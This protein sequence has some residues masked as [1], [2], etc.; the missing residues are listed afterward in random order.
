[1]STPKE[2]SNIINAITEIDLIQRLD[3][4]KLEY[5]DKTK[6][7]LV[8]IDI[9]QKQEFVKNYKDL[10]LLT[11]DDNSIPKLILKGYN[12]LDEISATN[13]L[14]TRVELNLSKL[15]KLNLSNNFITEMFDLNLTP[16]MKELILRENSIKTIRWEDFRPVKNSLE[17]FD[18]SLNKIDFVDCNKFLD[19]AKNFGKFMKKLDSFNIMGN[20]FS[21]KSIYKDYSTIFIFYIEANLELFLFNN[22][23]TKTVKISAEKIAVL[24][25]KM[26]NSEEAAK[27]SSAITQGENNNFDEG[28]N[29]NANEI[30]LSFIVNKIKKF[31]TM[32]KMTITTLKELNSLVNQY[33]NKNKQISSN[34]NDDLEDLELIEFDNF[35]D[36][37]SILIDTSPMFEK[38]IYFIVCD[39]INNQN[40]KFSSKI[41]IFLKQRI[42]LDQ[43]SDIQNTVLEHL[44]RRMDF[45]NRSVENIPANIIM[46]ME[47]LLHNIVFRTKP[48]FIE[49]TKK[50]IEYILNLDKDVKFI[51]CRL[52]K[53]FKVKETYHSVI[54]YLNTAAMIKEHFVQM[55]KNSKFLE[56]ISNQIKAF[57]KENFFVLIEDDISVDTFLKLM[58]IMKHMFL[59]HKKFL[60]QMVRKNA[61]SN[62]NPKESDMAQESQFDASIVLNNILGGGLRDKIEQTIN[63]RFQE[64]AKNSNSNDFN[65]NK[66]YILYAM[67]R[68]YGGLISNSP[69]LAKF[70]KDDKSIPFKIIN[71][72]VINDT[73]DPIFIQS[74]CEFVLSLLQN[75]NIIKFQKNS[76]EFKKILKN[77]YGLRYVLPYLVYDTIE[78]VNCCFTAEKYGE[79][80]VS[81]AKAVE[82]QHLQSPIMDS[83]II[84]IVQLIEFFGVNCKIETNITE[85]CKIFCKELQDQNKNYILFCCLNMPNELVKKAIVESLYSTDCG[86]FRSEEISQI[87]KLL[88]EASLT[89]DYTESIF[90]TIFIMLDQTFKNFILKNEIDRIKQNKEIFNLAMDILLKN[91]ER[92]VTLE[93]TYKK[94]VMLNCAISAFL[95][96]ICRYQVTSTFFK[97]K[98]KNKKFCEILQM[99]ENNIFPTAEGSKYPYYIP[100]EIEKIRSGLRVENLI[101]LI[102]NENYLTPFTF[103]SA[104]VM[105]NLADL[106]MNIKQK[107]IL[108]NTKLDFDSLM[109]EIEL[110]FSEREYTRI[111][112][113][114]L[115]F[116]KFIKFIKSKEEE[117]LLSNLDLKN[118]QMAFLNRF[119]LFMKYFKGETNN[120]INLIFNS[121]WKNKCDPKFEE[122]NM[123]EDDIKLRERK[124]NEKKNY[125]EICKEKDK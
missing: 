46:A 34:E 92:I 85:D 2:N 51:N 89:G 96:N 87:S 86:N 84:S 13:N 23:D 99:E 82:L 3:K 90:S 18:I 42:F 125:M 19:F 113:E 37:I 40:G 57:I 7:N 50:L 76:G 91:N 101:P 56:K 94:K 12:K 30:E 49:V 100:I 44:E 17:K 20:P 5:S 109:K 65:K 79:N 68:F 116:Q 69:D 61:N 81:R 80:T 62:K 8:N 53:E 102:T 111:T 77:L 11:V 9:F 48:S 25:K 114:T 112:L 121:I 124:E 15:T 105:I 122:K 60:K 64:M 43:V 26:K 110:D 39:F 36:L 28:N 117:P 97:D 24:E 67:I 22:K 107:E 47:N 33:L 88:M 54:Y 21:Q 83:M 14:I 35:L 31:T 78:Y 74:C 27:K 71:F 55:I 45:R 38:T 6:F 66:N 70:I 123:D 29:I 10:L 108:I 73:Y 115:N 119:D 104:R 59:L 1:M 106:L 103:V 118:E 4:T 63:Q 72:L 93:A 120:R 98:S 52:N 58:R 32:G 16:S 41:L 75:E 95:T